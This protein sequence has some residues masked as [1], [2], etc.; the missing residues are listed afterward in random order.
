MQEE[1]TVA[2]EP[3]LR[4]R[5]QIATFQI[6]YDADKKQL[7][8]IELTTTKLVEKSVEVPKIVAQTQ[9]ALRA[10]MHK[11]WS[12]IDQWLVQI[13]P[14]LRGTEFQVAVWNAISLIPAG[15]VITYRELAYRVGRPRATRAVGT[16][17]GANPFPFLIPCHR[18]VSCNGLGGYGY[19]LNCKKQLLEFEQ[20]AGQ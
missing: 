5:W 17:C 16:A 15:Q 18:V 9:R 3:G 7:T 11:D 8:S 13:R 6:S 2:L 14:Q 20:T 12:I 19:G 1:Y 10:F 4:A